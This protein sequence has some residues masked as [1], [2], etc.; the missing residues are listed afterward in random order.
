MTAYQFE[1]SAVLVKPPVATESALVKDA[2]T[3][4][5]GNVA[6]DAGGA[7]AGKY[8]L[9]TLDA[10]DGKGIAVE[11][12][13]GASTEKRPLTVVKTGWVR[14]VADGAIA[15]GASVKCGASARLKALAAA[16]NRKL[17]VGRHEGTAALADGDTGTFWVDFS[18]SGAEA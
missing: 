15:A 14:A 8:A 2:V 13:V 9:G 6:K 16:D 3:I 1:G 7:D 11:K 4:E 12:R 17:R 18:E 10:T 5:A